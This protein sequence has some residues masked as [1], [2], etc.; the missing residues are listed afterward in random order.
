MIKADKS[1]KANAGLAGLGVDFQGGPVIDPTANVMS[2]VE[3]S[4]RRQDDLREANSKHTEAI[5]SLRAEHSK[6]IASLESARLDSIRRVDQ[7]AVTTAA[8]RA[9]AAI[10]TLAATTNT[11]AENLRNALNTTA[12]TIATQ[13]ANTVNSITERISMLEKSSYEGKGKQAVSDPMMI[14][15]MAKMNS[16]I[17]A[18]ATGTGK[19]AGSAAMWGY[20]AAGFGFFL[21]LLGIAATLFALLRK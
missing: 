21:T 14:D 16:L 3:A 6:D 19:S 2:L 15:L 7:L 18:Q 1:T 10:Q 12:T 8:D 13:T 5:A 17:Q 4:N 20:V 9:L 11:N